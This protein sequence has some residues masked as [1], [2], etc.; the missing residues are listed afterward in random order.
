M[1]LSIVFISIYIHIQTLL[2][3]S[4]LIYF[5]FF[6]STYFFFPHLF[7]FLKIL[8]LSLI[9]ESLFLTIILESPYLFSFFSWASAWVM[10]AAESSFLVILLRI[11]LGS[12][13][14]YLIFIL[15]ITMF[16]HITKDEGLGLT[17]CF[18]A[19]LLVVVCFREEK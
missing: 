5:S 16:P 3:H 9:L 1:T 17:L 4:H 2:S 14:L 8:F 6:P 7:T 15:L 10:L 18:F 11:F 13:C 12:S 19:P